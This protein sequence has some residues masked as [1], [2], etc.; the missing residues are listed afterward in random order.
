ML[1]LFKKMLP[2]GT[3]KAKFEQLKQDIQNYNIDA[4]IATLSDMPPEEKLEFF[5]FPSDITQRM[6]V[7]MLTFIVDKGS[8]NLL[9]ATFKGLTAEQKVQALEEDRDFHPGCNAFERLDA[10]STRVG[11]SSYAEYRNVFLEGVPR[12]KILEWNN[13]SVQKMKKDGTF[14]KLHEGED[15]ALITTRVDKKGKTT[16]TKKDE[17]GDLGEVVLSDGDIESQTSWTKRVGDDDKLDRKTHKGVRHQ[18]Q[19]INVNATETTD[20]FLGR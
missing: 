10:F 15:G 20:K 16:I 18:P 12:K 9:R 4:A 5:K 13:G 8:V 2:S 3:K 17:N 14:W 11:P 1:A 7:N 6:Y 19:V